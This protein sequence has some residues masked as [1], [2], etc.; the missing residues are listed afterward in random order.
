VQQRIGIVEHKDI[1]TV[2]SRLLPTCSRADHAFETCKRL[3]LN[4]PLQILDEQPIASA[5]ASTRALFGAIFAAD[6][7]TKS[8]SSPYRLGRKSPFLL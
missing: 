8:Q 5:A 7:V 6:T 1:G 2:V 4:M 3:P